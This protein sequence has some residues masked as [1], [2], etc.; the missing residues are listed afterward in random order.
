[1]SFDLELID[2]DI[3]FDEF[4]KLIT[5]EDDAKLAQQSAKI[6]YE[7]QGDNLEDLEYGTVLR[8]MIGSRGDGQVLQNI[9][10]K[11]IESALQL[12]QLYQQAQISNDQGVSSK[13]RL[14]GYGNISITTPVGDPR[15]MYI[16]GDLY[17][18]AGETV[19][20][21]LTV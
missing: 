5:V 13:E 20:L 17:N 7:S 15:N 12:L 3:W 19:D 16:T 18:E 14:I 10:Q 21:E 4:G 11:S 2:G 6:V 1:M 9:A 8:G